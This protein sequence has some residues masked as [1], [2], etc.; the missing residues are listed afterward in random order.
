LAQIGVPAEKIVAIPNGVE[1]PDSEKKDYK[2]QGPV[3]VV[4]AGRLNPEKRCDLLMEALGEI[5]DDIPVRCDIFGEGPLRKSLEER[6]TERHLDAVVSFRGYAENL[7]EILSEYDVFVLSSEAEGMSNALLEAMAA[8]LSCVVSDIPPNR[9][10]VDPGRKCGEPKPGDYTV[11]K[12]GILFRSGDSAG[13]AKALRF[14]CEDE[15]IREKI[16]KNARARVLNDFSIKQ[17]AKRY[18][19]LYRRLSG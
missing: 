12:C 16:G 13:L 3:K 9:E 4:F 14:L 1:V 8:G 7:R 19:E 10:L 6:V 2:L 15:K 18:V 5:C 11:C 17:V